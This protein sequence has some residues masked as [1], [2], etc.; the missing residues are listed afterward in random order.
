MRKKKVA[1]EI[2]LFLSLTFPKA[3]APG[4]EGGVESVSSHSAPQAIEMALTE[5][6]KMGGGLSSNLPESRGSGSSGTFAVP[7]TP[8][9]TSYPLLLGTHLTGAQERNSLSTSHLGLTH[10]CTM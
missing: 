10:G 6:V 3:E 1:Q 9:G 8:S 7:R 4:S 2:G 5:L